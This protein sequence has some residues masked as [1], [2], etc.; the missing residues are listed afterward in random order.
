MTTRFAVAQQPEAQPR[1]GLSWQRSDRHGLITAIGL[2]GMATAVAMAVYGLPPVDLHGPLH[3]F[4]IMDPLCGGT[5]A[6][7]YTTQGQLA[8]AWKYNPLGIITVAMAAVAT[9]RIV[10]GLLSR[11]WLTL[12]VTWTPSRVKIAVTIGLVLLVMLEVRQQLLANLLMA[13][14]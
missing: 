6:A 14:T 1:L 9:T 3:R 10:V 5:R 12:H 8:L 7:Y 11:H 2:L 13:G 4:G